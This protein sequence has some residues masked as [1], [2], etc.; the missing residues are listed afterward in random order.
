MIADDIIQLQ[1]SPWANPVALV[2][3]RDGRML[4]RVDHRKLNNDAKDFYSQPRIDDTSGGLGHEKCFS[5]MDLKGGCWR[6]E[7]NDHGQVK[8]NLFTLHMTSPSFK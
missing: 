3:K 4:F 1:R 6:I 7:V 8:T 2:K 5:S